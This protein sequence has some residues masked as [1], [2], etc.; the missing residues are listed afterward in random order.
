MTPSRLAGALLFLSVVA[1]RAGAVPPG[2]VLE[3]FESTDPGELP[4]RWRNKSGDDEPA[5][6]DARLRSTY[7]YRVVEEDGNR[8][9]RFDGQRG[10]H[11]LLPLAG[12]ESIDLKTTPVL[13]WRWRI[14][15]APEGANEKHRERNDAAA[16]MYVVMGHKLPRIPKVLKYT[17][18]SSLP[19]GTEFSRH[20]G[21]LKVI[22]VGS[23]SSSQGQWVECE[24]NLRQDYRRLFGRRGFP[25]RPLALL[26]L[27]D[28]DDTGTRAVADYDDFGLFPE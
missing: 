11:L 9:L 19:V 3:D 6:Y 13:R 16:A 14:H 2:S 25:Q 10:K 17:W 7:H 4:S 27:S 26:I 22:V 23:G 24:R 21:G 12:D 5:T 28:A 8:F 20:L 15:R 18:S 1:L